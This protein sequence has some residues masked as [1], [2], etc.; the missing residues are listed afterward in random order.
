MVEA[1]MQSRYAGNNRLRVTGGR[2]AATALQPSPGLVHIV[3]RGSGDRLQAYRFGGAPSTQRTVACF[4]WSNRGTTQTEEQFK[5]REL[6][7]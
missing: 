1:S 7:S 2:V 3:D 6:S 5:P 4:W